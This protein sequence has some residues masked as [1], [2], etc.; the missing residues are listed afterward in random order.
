M[1]LSGTEP[2]PL[3]FFQNNLDRDKPVV[4]GSCNATGR[5]FE[6]SSNLMLSVF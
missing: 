3:E 6:K 2:P 5:D 4:S 1:L